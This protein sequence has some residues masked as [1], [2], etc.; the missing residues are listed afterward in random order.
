MTDPFYRSFVLVGAYW[1]VHRLSIL[2]PSFHAASRLPITPTASS[3][4]LFMSPEPFFAR[5][6]HATTGSLLAK[7]ERH[8]CKIH[9]DL[10]RRIKMTIPTITAAP[11]ATGRIGDLDSDPSFSMISGVSDLKN[12]CCEAEVSGTGVAFP[13][14]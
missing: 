5:I 14:F 12:G 10:R 7:T 3:Y 9:V 1:C 2:S 13:L 6:G 4:Q 11:I 8:G